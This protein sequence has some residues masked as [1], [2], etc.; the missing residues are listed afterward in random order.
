MPLSPPVISATLPLKPAG[1]VETSAGT[2]AADASCYSRPGWRVCLWGGCGMAHA[3]GRTAV[4]LSSRLAEGARGAQGAPADA[5]G[6]A[7][8]PKVRR[9]DRRSNL[10]RRRA[11]PRVGAGGRDR[12]GGAAARSAPA[13]TAMRACTARRGA[14]TLL[15]SN[16]VIEGE[17]RRAD[18]S[19][20]SSAK[21]CDKEVR[22]AAS[23]SSDR[24]RCKSFR[25]GGYFSIAT[26]MARSALCGAATPT[27]SCARSRASR[28]R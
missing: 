6:R 7:Y 8:M 24:A 21:P 10:R 28:F 25:A 19:R 16:V 12:S 1:A 3:A 9:S 18:V 2:P 13:A 11:D 26:P 27:S 23:R 15:K 22:C 14:T 20:T 4:S 17:P 5:A